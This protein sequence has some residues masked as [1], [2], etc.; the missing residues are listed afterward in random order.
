MSKTNGDK[1]VGRYGN[2]GIVANI[3]PD[4]MF[5]LGIFDAN[6]YITSVRM[7][8]RISNELVF[9]TEVSNLSSH[10]KLF[11]SS[12]S[13]SYDEKIKLI[14]DLVDAQIFPS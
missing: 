9:D 10:I 12:R 14:H 7:C 11:M 13:N 6:D 4:L 2:K 8:T 1:V 3:N 5:H